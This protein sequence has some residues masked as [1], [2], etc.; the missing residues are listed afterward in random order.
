MK[1]QG[2]FK[3]VSRDWASND[4]ILSFYIHNNVTNEMIDEIRD[5]KLSIEV[6]QYREKRSLN[7]NSYFHVL[8]G[9]L[10]DVLRISKPRCKNILLH[11]YG[12]PLLLDDE[13]EAVIKTNI[14]PSQML[15]LEEPHCFPCGS[16]IEEN[17]LETIYYKLR[18]NSRTYDSREMSILIDGTVQECKE[19]GIE[20]MPPAELERLIKSWVAKNG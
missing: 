8:V 4:F 13:S 3:E 7:A 2:Q 5:S 16:K 12:Q 17:G 18:R 11:R 1:V 14:Q 9:K 19:Q 15:E 10:A 6:K 20:T